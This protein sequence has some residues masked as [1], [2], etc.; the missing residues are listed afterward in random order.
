MKSLLDLLEYPKYTWKI[1][2]D[3]K[4]VSFLLGLQ[5]GYTKHMC[6]L[7]L[8]DRRKDISHYAVNVWPPRQSSQIE[9]H[10]PLVSFA[11]VLLPLVH[12][13][14][15]LMKNFVKAMDRDGDGFK[16]FK[17]FF[18]AEKTDAKLEAG[19]FVGPEIKKLM[20]NEEFG[21]RLNPLELAAW[22]A[23]KS[24]VV[25]FLGNHRHEKYPDIVDSMLKA[26]EQLGARMS[27]KMHFLHSHLDFFPSNLGEVSD[28]QE[29][30]FHQDISVIEE[31]YQGGYDANMMGDFC[32]YLKRES[33]NSS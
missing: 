13:K 24:V 9:K 29:E 5:L 23:I 22:N 28:E 6:F 2:S 31:R 3:L 25:N 21:A 17:D 33:K 4:V 8:C 27:L 32:W 15:D 30:R 11:H 14:L 18:G 26:Y 20:Q 1:C 12:I 19:V 16:F 7:C 10:L